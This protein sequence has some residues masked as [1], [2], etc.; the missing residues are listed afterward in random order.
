MIPV[1]DGPTAVYGGVG[2]KGMI[3]M[4]MLTAQGSLPFTSRCTI[5]PIFLSV[6]GSAPCANWSSS[7]SAWR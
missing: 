6:E 7:L 1:G 3:G 5:A 2:A 4:L